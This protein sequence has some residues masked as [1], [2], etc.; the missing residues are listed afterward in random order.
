MTHVPIGDMPTEDFRRAGHALIDWIADHLSR[1][2][3]IPVL[4]DVRPGEIRAQLPLEAPEQGESI[5][6]VLAD[7]DRIIMPGMTHWNHPNFM[8]YFGI[9]SSG[10]A[11][12][13]E[14]LSAALNV[15]AMLWTTCPVAT[16][17]EKTVMDWL[18]RMLGLPESFWGMI[19]DSAS[20]S[21]LQAIAA[22]R[23]AALD[24]PVR[25]KGLFGAPRLRLYTS[26]QAHS[27]VEKAAVTLG[28]GTESV[29]K[30]G[31][32]SSYRLDP[33]LLEQAVTADRQA[34]LLPFCVVA[35][36]GTTSTTSI[37]PVPAIADICERH[38]LWLHV[39]AAYGGSPAII[40]E[41]RH[42]LAGC[43]RADSLLVNPHKWLFVPIDCSAFYTR[44]P[45]VL[46]QAFSLVP[47]Y[48]KTNRDDEVENLMDYGVQLG[49]RFR[50]LKLWFTIRY[51]GS[52]GL[53][54]RIR[55]AIDLAQALAKKIDDHPHFETLAPVPYS[56]ICFRAHPPEIEDES[57]L[58]RLNRTLLDNI[59]A[60]QQ[61]FLSHTRLNGRLALRLAIGNL[62]TREKH[63]D[64]AWK[65]IQ[66][67]WDALYKQMS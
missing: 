16:E 23:E 57:V 5:D 7:V 3:K 64:Q 24:H 60:G 9:S 12:L 29:Y 51:F 37:D 48:L 67:Q 50:A 55:Y 8:A 40:A 58:D 65:L 34:G 59:L 19:T 14:L 1:L 10:P 11:I 63:V 31:V 53:G 62:Y 39:D 43:D 22:A 41:Y 45:A 18:R 27:S 4:P 17:L 61:L 30:I 52:R 28:L 25:Q 49:R 46:K 56:T 21:T 32:D 47:E 13:G 2:D 26:E 42:V 6:D 66:E 36:V 33:V 44:K 20:S 15:N 54:E 35:T 38:N